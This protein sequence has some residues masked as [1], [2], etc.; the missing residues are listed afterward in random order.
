MAVCRTRIEAA[1]LLVKFHDEGLEDIEAT[2]EAGHSV[3]E[4]DLGKPDIGKAAAGKL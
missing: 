3:D 2:D 4:Q 1:Q